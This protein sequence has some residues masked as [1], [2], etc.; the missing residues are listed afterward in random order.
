MR[1][2]CQLR[3]K[4]WRLKEVTV[5]GELRERLGMAEDDVVEL[6]SGWMSMKESVGSHC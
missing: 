5:K 1:V 2:K 3:M 6:E 4:V